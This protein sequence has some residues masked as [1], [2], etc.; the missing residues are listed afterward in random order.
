[1]NIVEAIRIGASTRGFNA[2]LNYVIAI[3]RLL[4]YWII[5]WNG[6]LDHVTD[7]FHKRIC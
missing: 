1:M 6:D 7:R 4:D 5:V 3:I 2:H